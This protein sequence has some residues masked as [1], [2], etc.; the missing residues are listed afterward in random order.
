MCAEAQNRGQKV[1]VITHRTQLGKALCNRFG[2]DYVSQLKDS[3]TQGVFGFGLCFD[4][5]RRGGQAQFNPD[6]WHGCI[7]ILDEC[8]QSIWHLLNART[9]VAKHRVP[10]LRNFQQ[11]IQNTLESDEG[12]VY[13]SDAD[14]SDLS[15]DY[16]RSLASFP[17]EPWV[18]VK[19][20]NPTPWDVTVWKSGNETLGAIMSYLRRGKRLIIS[21]DGQKAK[22]KWGTRNLENYLRKNF[23]DLRILR[24]DSES[25]SDPKH[26]A[27]G[28]VESLNEVL[29]NYDVVICS[30]S[31]ETGV[32]IDIKGH[33][34]A[35]FDI[36]QGVIPVA[37]VLQRSALVTARLH[38]SDFWIVSKL[39][40]RH[41]LIS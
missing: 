34:S 22:S 33:F 21:V 25:I 37:S 15:V 38:P 8:E 17:V 39:K 11:L 12:R 1:I 41:T 14:L 29:L 32:S 18:A 20:G 36:A 10:V 16:V 24:I 28:C 31:I 2:I 40:S 35:V 6:D 4:S 9:E 27:F 23:P 26:P 7:V 13:L 30:P 3:D 5:L 19:E